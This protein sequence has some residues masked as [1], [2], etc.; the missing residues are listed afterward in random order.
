[1]TVRI[2]SAAISAVVLSLGLGAA[3]A[4]AMKWK[5]GVV[6]PYVVDCR[7]GVVCM[8]NGQIDWVETCYFFRSQH[9][10][11]CEAEGL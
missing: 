5:R 6:S 11:F 2:A 8:R 7:S 3:P 1:M 9:E 4:D 10:T